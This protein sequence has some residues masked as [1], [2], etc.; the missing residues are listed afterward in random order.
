MFPCAVPVRWA[1]HPRVTHP[2]AASATEVAFARLACLRRAASVRSE[3]GSNS[4]SLPLANESGFFCR[5]FR[6]DRGS[7][8]STLSLSSPS[9]R[10][11]KNRSPYRGRHDILGLPA[12]SVKR[13]R[14]ASRPLKHRGSILHASALLVN[15]FLELFRIFS[16][17]PPASRYRQ[18]TYLCKNFYVVF[19]D[20]S[21]GTLLCMILD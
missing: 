7:L 9:L 1:G 2:S 14:S 8:A 4:P 13:L 18:R 3:P 21:A 20:P 5:S 19:K 10:I 6:I 11:P 16:H 17:L 15:P 12:S